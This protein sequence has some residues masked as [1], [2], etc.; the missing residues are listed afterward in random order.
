MHHVKEDMEPWHFTNY[1]ALLDD[2]CLHRDI[3]PT[4]ASRLLSPEEGWDNF[5]SHIVVVRIEGVA[6]IDGN[7]TASG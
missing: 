1:R 5:N 2:C 3:E 7:G 4:N 6:R